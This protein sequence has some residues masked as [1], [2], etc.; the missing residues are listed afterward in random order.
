MDPLL[1]LSHHA[2]LPSGAAPPEEDG[3]EGGGVDDAAA[4]TLRLLLHVRK[5]AAA[6]VLVTLLLGHRCADGSRVSVSKR[7]LCCGSCSAAPLACACMGL[8]ANP[9]QG[10]HPPIGMRW[11]L[12]F[13]NCAR[14]DGCCGVADANMPPSSSTLCK[15]N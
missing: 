13:C 11:Q 4:S 8:C 3:D 15:D 2:S 1:R 10:V 6:L 7:P 14:L 12:C 5:A 9:A